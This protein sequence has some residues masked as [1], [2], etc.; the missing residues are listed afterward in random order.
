MSLT[1]VFIL[2]CLRTPRA[3]VKAG[4]S[5]LS[6]LHPQE[7][8]GQ[9]L[10]ALVE[11]SGVDP[12]KIDDIIMGC[13][14]EVG[15]QGAN[16]ARNAALTAGLPITAGGVTLNRCCASG[17]QAINFG[18][19][20]VGSTMADLILAGGVESMSRVQ[21]ASDG[22]GL[23][24]N[25]ARLR[26][27]YLQVTQGVSAD[28]IATMENFSKNDLD[29]FAVSSQQKA[30]IAQKDGRFD[31]SLVT[32]VDP[33]TGAEL[34]S[35]DN[36]L[37]PESTLESL[38]S[39]Q[40]AFAKIGASPL[41]GDGKTVDQGVLE[42]FP[43]VA[44]IDHR[45]TA[46]TASGIVDGAAAVL[47]C[48]QTFLD[49]NNLKARG[50]IVSTAVGGSDPVSMMVGQADI[51]K[52]ALKLAGMTL[53]DID[54]FEINEA[55]AAIPLLVAHKLGIDMARINVNGGSIALGHP[56]GATGAMLLGTALDE[57]ERRDLNTAVI[58]LCAAGGQAIATIIERHR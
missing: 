7:L 19:A 31:R 5:A 34:L 27:K 49:N 44:Q 6:S 1:G 35:A 11:K 2:D 42:Y 45:H 36:Y 43:E 57:L 54:L 47:L 32:V 3:R 14:S 29:Q 23:D 39:L 9:T 48:S 50:R 18:A 58:T 10:K 24:G 15:E 51:V 8:L 13:V 38:A 41:N 21:M 26:E 52:K 33:S 55:F 40:P 17:L 30:G 56:L 28:L 12:T 22:G 53:A 25:N 4:G 20:E 37:R 16:I 46:G